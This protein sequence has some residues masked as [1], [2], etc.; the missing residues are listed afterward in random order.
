MIDNGVNCPLCGSRT[1][2]VLCDRPDHEYGHPARLEYHRCTA[3]DCRFV[4]AA[5]IPVEA[6]P[7]FYSSYSTHVAPDARKPSGLAARLASFLLPPAIARDRARYDGAWIPADA[8]LRILDFGCGNGRLLKHLSGRGF[9]HVEG[10]DADPKARAAA[11]SQGFEVHHDLQELES[12]GRR[13]DVI[14]LN[15]VVEHLDQPIEVLQRLIGLLSD[16]G[17]LYL[18]TP[19]TGSL[20]CRAMGQSWRGY[21]TP[22]HLHL[23]NPRNAR[24]LVA[25]LPGVS[26]KIRTEN[27][28]LQ[29]MFHESLVARF[30]RNRVGKGVRHLAFPG[31]AWLCVA[32][33]GV[34]RT[35][36]EELV[37]ELRRNETR[38]GAAGSQ[39]IR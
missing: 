18:R 8:S 39:A 7:S 17:V 20:L 1:A 22:R 34:F 31:V 11:R 9:R 25:R 32:L 19:N 30:W 37:V 23:F 10:F 28:L 27:A 13:F 29:G 16:R 35:V 4:F 26:A 24:H 3:A 21:E 6:I 5:P 12:S 36:G 14:V 2:R 15:H 38:S 33:N